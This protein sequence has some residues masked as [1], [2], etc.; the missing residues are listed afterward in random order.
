[1]AD[2]TAMQRALPHTDH[3]VQPLLDQ[4][5]VARLFG[6]TVATVRVWTRNRLLPFVRVGGVTRYV[7]AD[8]LE[9]AR[10]GGATR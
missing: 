8:L 3:E 4:K 9:A 7:L 1:M 2:S 10:Q 5:D 6:V